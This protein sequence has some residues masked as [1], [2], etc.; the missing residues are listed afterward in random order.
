VS[1]L[2]I[3]LVVQT[4]DRSTTLFEHSVVLFLAILRLISMTIQDV[5]SLLQLSSLLLL[6]GLSWTKQ[7][8]DDTELMNVNV[9]SLRSHRKRFLRS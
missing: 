3:L 4:Q 8:I 5:V 6:E 1:V 2:P 9:K 7:D